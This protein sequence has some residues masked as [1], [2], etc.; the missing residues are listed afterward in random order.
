MCRGDKCHSFRCCR[1]VPFEWASCWIRAIRL[2]VAARVIANSR[3]IGPRRRLH[4]AQGVGRRRLLR[5]GERLGDAGKLL[6]RLDCPL[7]GVFSP[8]RGL[9][10]A[11]HPRVLDAPLTALAESAR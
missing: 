8:I 2:D 4:H 11:A 1:D 3:A 7:R 10:T 9:V 5:V 6:R